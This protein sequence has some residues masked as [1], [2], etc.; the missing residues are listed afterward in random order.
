MRAI[1]GYLIARRLFL[2]FFNYGIFQPKS[3]HNVQ[4]ADSWNFYL[5]ANEIDQSLFDRLSLTS[6]STLK[7]DKI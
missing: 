4:P 6:N 5:P 3:M 2:E 1:V 7:S